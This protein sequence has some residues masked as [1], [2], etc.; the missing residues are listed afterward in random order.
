[1]LTKIFVLGFFPSELTRGSSDQVNKSAWDQETFKK[2]MVQFGA[3]IPA[4][5]AGSEQEMASVSP[6]DAHI[7]GF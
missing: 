3:V 5:R 6:L 7:I 1:M 4:G 2:D